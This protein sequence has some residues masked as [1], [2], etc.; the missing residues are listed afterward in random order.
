MATGE[1][2]DIAHPEPITPTRRLTT[3]AALL[4]KRAVLYYAYGI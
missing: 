3:E 4:L 2:I 1:V